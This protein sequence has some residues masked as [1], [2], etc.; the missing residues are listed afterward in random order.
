M[1]A[2]AQMNAMMNETLNIGG[3]LLVKL[4]G[5]TATGSRALPASAPA[6]VRDIGHPTG[7]W[8][9]QLFFV[10]IGLL[11][12]VGTALVYGIGGYLVIQQAF[13]IG[14]IVA[15]GAYLG[16]LYGA[17]QGLA[18]APVDFATSMVSFERVFE[19]IDLPA[20]IDDRAGRARA[21][22]DVRG[23]LVFE[24]VSFQ[25]RRWIADAAQRGGAP[26]ADGQ[27]RPRRSQAEPAAEAERQALAKGAAGATSAGR[28]RS[29]N[30]SESAVRIARRART[31][32]RT[33]PFTSSRASW[34]RWSGPAARARPPSPT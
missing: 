27:R 25:L 29:L 34:W 4:F 2:N 13:T 28:M 12:A 17:L 24:D 3:A 15:F 1:E 21:A 8:S 14:T 9:G 6:Q 22:A 10:I 20:E 30:R 32:W 11:S 5:R 18:N 26:W 19:V 31:P 7:R 23:E 16:S 33:S